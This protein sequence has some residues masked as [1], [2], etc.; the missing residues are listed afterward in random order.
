MGDE[1]LP[2]REIT[3]ALATRDKQAH[4]LPYQVSD[5][6]PLPAPRFAH[7]HEAGEERVL[8]GG[9]PEG[10]HARVRYGEV[11]PAVRRV[12]ERAAR[13]GFPLR[14]CWCSRSTR[15]DRE[16]TGSLP[17]GGRC[18]NVTSV[19]RT[20]RCPKCNGQRL[21]VIDTFR[22]P[23]ESAAG[24]V[25]P[26]VT[27]QE[28]S[29]GRFSLGRSIPQGSFNLWLCDACGYSELWAEKISGLRHDPAA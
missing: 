13:L 20:Q 6:S 26:V 4:N 23:G 1:T 8:R 10:P 16:A 11:G 22:V 15:A 7:R 9:A 24:V 2:L 12:E 14:R 29:T 28:Q 3:N 5:R 18:G 21:W 19:K 27:H 17:R 25:L